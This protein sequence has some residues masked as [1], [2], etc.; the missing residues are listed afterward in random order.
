MSQD[1]AIRALERAAA[2]G[3]RDAALALIHAEAN[4]GGWPP[5]VPGQ[6]HAWREDESFSFGPTALI[7]NC[8]RWGDASLS[9]TPLS[10][11]SGHRT[12]EPWRFVIEEREWTFGGAIPSGDHVERALAEA[13]FDLRPSGELVLSFWRVELLHDFHGNDGPSTLHAGQATGER[14]PGG[15]WAVKD[16]LG[17]NRPSCGFG[18]IFEGPVTEQ[19]RRWLGAHKREVAT[20]WRAVLLRKA[21]EYKDD[22]DRRERE[23]DERR[24]AL[25]EL[26]VAEARLRFL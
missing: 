22:L 19:A 7:L 23:A 13:T 9:V 5:A 14:A 17:G 2:E 8:E 16:G 20:A 6:A 3:D 24:S 15:S 25:A 1:A 10:L 26:I 18:P 21:R 4:A 11:A 12:I